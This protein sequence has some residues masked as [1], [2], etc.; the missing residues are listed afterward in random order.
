VYVGNKSQWKK[1]AALLRRKMGRHASPPKA[2]VD[3]ETGHWLPLDWQ[4]GQYSC[5]DS[6]L[7]VLYQSAVREQAAGP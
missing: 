2:S 4:L 7:S 3:K 5:H 6:S 1:A